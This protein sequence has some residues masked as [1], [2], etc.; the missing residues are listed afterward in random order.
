[1]KNHEGS[2]FMLTGLPASGKSYLAR[3]YMEKKNREYQD[4]GLEKQVVWISSDSI[5]EELFGSE[6]VQG[7][8]NKVFGMM[9]KRTDAALSAGHDVIYDACN[10]SEKR[11][12]T[13]LNGL[14][15]FSCQKICLIIATPFAVC[16]ERNRARERQVPKEVMYRMY[17]SWHTPA[18]FEGWDRIGILYADGAEGSAGTPQAFIDGLM[19][20]EQ[21]N[22]YHEE[23][24]GVHMRDTWQYLVSRGVC[25]ENSNLAM[26]ALLHDCGKPFTKGFYDSRGN[27]SEIAHY[28]NHECV[29]AYDA[30]FFRYPKQTAAD[31]LE[32][33]VLIL[34][35]MQPFNW[36]NGPGGEKKKALWGQELYDLVLALHEADMNAKVNRQV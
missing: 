6:E 23:S 33:S 21:D 32:I 10:V 11:R 15:R 29:G 9:K 1:M 19:D 12:R 27:V 26:A 22:P 28:Y 7:D 5:R 4:A 30:L 3:Q 8:N 18:Y 16:M 2:F 14:K 25:E 20:F 36:R 13:F 17:R 31:V 24:L 35:H 34:L